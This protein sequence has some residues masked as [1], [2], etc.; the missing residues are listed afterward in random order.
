MIRNDWKK[1][2]KLFFFDYDYVFVK[3]LLLHDIQNNNIYEFPCITTTTTTII[4]IIYIYIY[5]WVQVTPG[6]TLVKL[7]LF[8]IVDF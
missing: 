7:H 8:Y 2:Q 6:V 1:K 3:F 5:G 4:I